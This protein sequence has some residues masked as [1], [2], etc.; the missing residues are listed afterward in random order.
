MPPPLPSSLSLLLSHLPVRSQLGVLGAGGVQVGPHGGE[1]WWWKRGGC[2][3]ATPNFQSRLSLP[4]LARGHTT[5][6]TGM[7]HTNVIRPPAT[8]GARCFET[9]A[10]PTRACA[11][12]HA[13]VFLSF[14]LL[15]SA[16]SE[17][18]SAARS[19]PT[20]GAPN[21]SRKPASL[22]A[23][24]WG[25]EGGRSSSQQ[26]P[27]FHTPSHTRTRAQRTWPAPTR[28]T[29]WGCGGGGGGVFRAPK[30]AVQTRASRSGF[31]V[32]DSLRTLASSFS[33]S[34]APLPL[35]SQWLSAPPSRYA[36]RLGCVWVA[37]QL[38][39]GEN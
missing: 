20:D 6:H 34:A 5:R 31:F 39:G 19:G 1:L 8:P 37:R 25:R 24:G 17:S 14:L 4:A 13:R 28:P 15:T 23:W 30:S 7:L 29:W 27:D 2:V 9:R 3:W 11:R 33:L 35:P 18:T 36:P 16:L 32:L 26:S 22:W 12:M 38:G 10:P 21:F